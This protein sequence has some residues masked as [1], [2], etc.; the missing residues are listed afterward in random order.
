MRMNHA[1]NNTIAAALFWIILTPAGAAE[2]MDG[3]AVF[4]KVCFVCHQSGIAG[5]PRYGDAADWAVRL[6]DGREKLYH[7]AL[8]GTPNGMPSKG[9]Q[10]DLSDAEV[11]SAVDFM[12]AAVK[13]AIA[14]NPAL[15]K[16]VRAAPAPPR[17]ISAVQ[18]AAA[19]VFNRLLRKGV[20]NPPP[21]EDGIHDPA[22]KGTDLLQ[23]P[24]EAYAGLPAGKAG[25]NVD[26]VAALAAN[27]ITPRRERTGAVADVQVM[28]MNI[29]RVP[30]SSMPN[31]LFPH[32]QHTEW[33]DCS[34][35]HPAIFIPRKGA[36]QI[37][38]AAILLGQKCGVCHGK[39]AFPPEAATCR[40]CHSQDK[41]PPWK[42]RVMR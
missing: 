15:S 36:N 21:A 5:A 2:Q 11:K 27:Q 24:L 16:A 1:M 14:G 30:N 41:V 13:D 37:S 28:D 9:G 26:W 34:N 29:L 32:K 20:K 38:M 33:L 42:P 23:A 4:G 17:V 7:S 39:V 6:A 35:C 40:K 3:K 10:P 12:L 22:N 25:N 19:N 18:P 31:V 8:H